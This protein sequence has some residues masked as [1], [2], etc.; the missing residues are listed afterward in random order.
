MSPYSTV[1]TAGNASVGGHQAGFFNSLNL[2]R[3]WIGRLHEVYWAP[4]DV[5]FELSTGCLPYERVLTERCP[6]Q[7]AE[8][9]RGCDRYNLHTYVKMGSVKF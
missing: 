6:H 5:Y 8:D 1:H 7:L 3:H 2:Q 9:Q 4:S